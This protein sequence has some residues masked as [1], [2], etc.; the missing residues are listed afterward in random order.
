MVKCAQGGRCP[1][2][3]WLRFLI[4]FVVVCHGITYAMF[5]FL[6][7]RQ[8]KEW[9][10]TSR[11]LGRM[12]TANRLNAAIPI[13]HVVA[14]VAVITAGIAIAVAPLVPGMW[15]PLAIVGGV[16]SLAAF[17]TFWDGRPRYLV[18]EGG[19]GL[20]LSVILLVGALV[21]PRAFS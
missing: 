13:A 2:N 19:I 1:L 6:G 18:Q 17:S 9:L 12:L 14:G 5:G 4:A 20:G 3:E 8:M 16:A 15:S 21:A 10:G 7:P 11:I